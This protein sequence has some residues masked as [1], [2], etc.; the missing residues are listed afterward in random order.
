MGTRR[1]LGFVQRQIL[2]ALDS[3]RT[4]QLS[5]A[6]PPRACIHGS[7]TLPLRRYVLDLL[8][9]SRRIK[10][11]HRQNFSR[12]VGRLC[13]LHILKPVPASEALETYAVSEAISGRVFLA[14]LSSRTRFVIPGEAW[15][16]CRR[17]HWRFQRRR[18]RQPW[19]KTPAGIPVQSV[20]PADRREAQRQ[21]DADIIRNYHGTTLPVGA[22]VWPSVIPGYPVPDFAVMPADAIRLS[23]W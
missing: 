20:S 6:E 4:A 8:A 23:D 16:E 1:K 2:T 11:T 18:V 3:Q 10:P 13:Q 22:N 17:N 14:S 7:I 15:E 5:A 9:L 21:T 12:L 19:H